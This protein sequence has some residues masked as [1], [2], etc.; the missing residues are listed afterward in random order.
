MKALAKVGVK[1]VALYFLCIGVFNSIGFITT[2]ILEYDTI[3]SS[4]NIIQA[5]IIPI[6]YIGFGVLLWSNSGL[7]S[8]AIIGKTNDVQEEISVNFSF[9]LLLRGL[10][11]IVGII[12][13]IIAI[14]KIISGICFFASYSELD[15]SKLMIDKKA[16]MLE[17][18]IKLILGVV[19][20]IGVKGISN[21]LYKLGN[22]GNYKGGIDENNK[23][24]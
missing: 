5:M 7:I 10:I 2:I 4:I 16:D 9:D 6:C 15:G 17:N 1:I 14:P 24:E 19:L 12:V 23:N 18:I 20:T 8:N 21:M 3:S 13:M 22:L 11:I